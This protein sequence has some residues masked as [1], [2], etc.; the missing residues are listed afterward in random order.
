[1]HPGQSDTP[2]DEHE[3]YH[4]RITESFSRILQLVQQQ[5]GHLSL[6]AENG[7]LYITVALPEC[8]K[9]FR[10]EF[11]A[12][13]TEYSSVAAAKKDEQWTHLGIIAQKIR[14]VATAESFDQLRQNIVQAEEGTRKTH[15]RAWENVTEEAVREKQRR[16]LSTVPRK[17]IHSKKSSPSKDPVSS[18]CSKPP[19]V[20]DIIR[21]AHPLLG[22]PEVSDT[23][24]NSLRSRISEICKT[25]RER[26]SD[27]EARI[28]AVYTAAS[29]SPSARDQQLELIKSDLLAFIDGLLG[30]EE[31]TRVFP[32]FSNSN[33]GVVKGSTSGD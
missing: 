27:F 31:L 25:A 4:L 10:A 15:F 2:D 7:K 8:S 14:M 20:A 11:E 12:P 32:P 23:D 1:M 17:R 24:E 33:L 18:K 26:R 19:V 28:A 16:K 5:D 6:N 21:P 13:L 9:T 3:Y 22:L 29:L 30:N